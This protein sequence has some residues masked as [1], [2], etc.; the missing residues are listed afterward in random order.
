MSL[1]R[2]TVL[3]LV[4]YYLPA[5]KAGGPVVSVSNLRSALASDF[6]FSI[7]SRD[8]DLGEVSSFPNREIG[9]WNDTTDG[10]VFYAAAHDTRFRRLVRLMSKTDHDVLFLNSLF[11]IDFSIKPLIARRLGLIPRKPLV[12][13]PRGEFAPAALKLKYWKKRLFLGVARALDLYRDAVWMASSEREADDIR[14]GLSRLAPHILIA[15]DLPRSRTDVTEGM[16]GGS[17]HGGLKIVHLSRISPMKNLD[18]GL[19]AL[20]LVRSVVEFT[21][22]GPIEDATYWKT[23]TNLISQMPKNIR[24]SYRGAV[25]P[26]EVPE[27][28]AAHDLFFLPTRGENFGHVVVESLS[29]GTPVLVSE[30]TPWQSGPAHSCT[31]I[32]LGAGES[33]FAE[34]IDRVAAMSREQRLAM[35]SAAAEL[36]RK[37]VSDPLV[38]RDN[39]DLFVAALSRYGG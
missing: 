21:I 29:V 12:I 24:V 2:P 10:M 20:A 27:V 7:I 19:R 5:F 15:P 32:P 11:D 33:E 22:F 17:A 18:F 4:S 3:A 39:R 34:F 36:G 16:A 1:E 30:R 25:L 28:L 13:A 14:A 8:R 26:R 35:R 6:E 31:V 23:C 9:A 38:V 37:A